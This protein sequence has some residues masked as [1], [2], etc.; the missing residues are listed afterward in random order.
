MFDH[1]I[2][3]HAYDGMRGS[4]RGSGDT[5]PMLGRTVAAVALSTALCACASSQK[6]VSVTLENQSSASLEVQVDLPARGPLGKKPNHEAYRTLLPPGMVWT[7][8][9][10]TLRF[11]TEPNDV[12]GFRIMVADIGAEPR[13]WYRP[14]PV[15]GSRKNCH[16]I[17]TGGPGALHWRTPA[18]PEQPMVLYEF[19]AQ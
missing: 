10:D 18:G 5:H 16:V 13:V 6:P 11:G 1:P 8:S 19:S 4:W 3:M 17:F 15:E 2:P 14:F 12:K 7:N 9:R